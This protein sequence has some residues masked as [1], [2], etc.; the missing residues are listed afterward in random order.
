[1][2]YFASIYAILKLSMFKF[3]FILESLRSGKRSGHQVDLFDQYVY[4]ARNIL[5]VL[6]SECKKFNITYPILSLP[7]LT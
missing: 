1:M 4:E 2:K 3:H 5:S 7:N 6:F